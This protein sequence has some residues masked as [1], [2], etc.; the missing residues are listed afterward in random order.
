VP[1][2]DLDAGAQEH[3]VS[4]KLYIGNLPFT[5]TEADLRTLFARHGTVASVN[6][7]M[8]RETGRPRGFAFV[9]MEEASAAS[10]AIRALDGSDLGGRSIKVNEAQDRR[11]DAGGGFLP[12]RY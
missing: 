10:D 4:K 7:I 5:S 2:S 11:G 8:D 12:N 3:Q 1:P 6:V 9:E